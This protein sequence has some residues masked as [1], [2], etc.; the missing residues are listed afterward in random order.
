MKQKRIIY[1]NENIPGGFDAQDIEFLTPED[2]TEDSRY[3]V[4]QHGG[5]FFYLTDTRLIREKV[6]TIDSSEYTVRSEF[7]RKSDQDMNALLKRL[8]EAEAADCYKKVS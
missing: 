6:H 7:N 1:E 5:I 4:R 2:M 3:A 8:V